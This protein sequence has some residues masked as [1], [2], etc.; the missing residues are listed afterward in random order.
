MGKNHPNIANRWESS[1]RNIY[2]ITCDNKLCQFCFNLLHRILVTNKEL[3]RFGIANDVNCVMCDGPD[4]LEHTFLECCDFL[5]LL[6]ASLL[7]FNV[8][9]FSDIKLSLEAVLLNLLPSSLPLSSAS[10]KK[11]SHFLFQVKQYFYSCK[12]LRKTIS[13]NEFISILN[14]QWK[15]EKLT[16]V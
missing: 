4:S 9:H 7:W 3:N 8:Q 5:K 6:E 16:Q 10:W 1:I 14:M 13:F 15:A 11:L 12:V 2:Q